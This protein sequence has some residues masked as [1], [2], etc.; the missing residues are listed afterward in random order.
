MA[1]KLGKREKLDLLTTS[2]NI[3][4]LVGETVLR[5]FFTRDLVVEEEPARVKGRPVPLGEVGAWVSFL[6]AR[7]DEKD[8]VLV[9][10]RVEGRA[11]FYGAEGPREMQWE[12]EIRGE[13]AASGALPGMEVGTCGRISFIQ[14]EEA[15]LEAEGKLIYQL[16][17]EVEILISISDPQQLEVAVGVKDIPPEKVERITFTADEL[18]AE[19]SISLSFAKETEF[20]EDLQYLKALSSSL[21]NFSWDED[22]EGVTIKGELETTFYYMAGEEKGFRKESQSIKHHIPFSGI[23]KDGYLNLFPRVEYVSYDLLGRRARQKVYL[24]LVIRSTR[25]VKL[26]V[27]SD[28]QGAEIKKEYI[29][30]AR[31]VGIVR[32]KIE[33]IQRLSFPFPRKIA[34]GGYRLLQLEVEAQED[35]LV[36]SGSLEKSISYIP[37]PERGSVDE[38]YDSLPLMVKVEEEFQR[39]AYLPGTG[40]STRW[41]AFFT[42][43]NTDFAPAEAAT[44]QVSHTLLEVKTW[45]VKEVP[46]VVPFRVPPETSMVVYAV[47][48]GDTLLK[49]ARN[50]GVEP[51]L[52]IKANNL[53]EDAALVAGQKLLIPL[54]LA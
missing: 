46:V 8:K 45:E 33:L 43:E 52:I 22:K 47:K 32:E 34:A 4:M 15:P 11:V 21:R 41:A 35:R 14:G 5:C 31:A 23:K 48:Q 25:T 51:A 10:G 24:N 18:L 2:L 50:Y 36:V 44:L 12:E 20:K 7:I 6:E 37:A 30:A 42:I 49:I 1:R 17:V 27:L 39:T 40:E 16:G 53:E 38:V 29:P 13:A 26:E 28:I 54:M 19:E 3:K 9:W